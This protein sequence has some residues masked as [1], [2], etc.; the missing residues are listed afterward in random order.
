MLP[1]G[2]TTHDEE[3][4]GGSSHRR[5]EMHFEVLALQDPS[6]FLAKNPGCLCSLQTH[7]API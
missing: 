2:G 4:R 6:Q 1:K 3:N 5:E 7:K